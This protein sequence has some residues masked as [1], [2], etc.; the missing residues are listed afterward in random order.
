MRLKIFG[1]KGNSLTKLCHVTCRYVGV[2]TR[3][4]LFLRGRGKGTVPLKFRKAK[5]V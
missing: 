5:N 3:T 2:I 1:A 4:Q